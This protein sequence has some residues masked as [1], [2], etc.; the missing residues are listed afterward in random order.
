VNENIVSL[1]FLA[2]LLI[3]F[4]SLCVFCAVEGFRLRTKLRHQ[5]MA[6]GNTDAFKD[7]AR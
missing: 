7:L 1:V 6:A 3:G 2:F 4:A 5:K